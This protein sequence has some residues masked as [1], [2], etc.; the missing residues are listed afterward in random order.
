MKKYLIIIII[1]N[2][3]LINAQVGSTCLTPDTIHSIPF[4]S[5]GHTT[6]G[7]GNNY[8]SSDLCN[9]VYTS[10]NDYVFMFKSPVDINLHITVNVASNQYG[11]GVFVVKNCPGSIYSECI[12]KDTA[13]SGNLEI[14]NAP[15]LAD[16]TYY[17]VLS[18]YDLMGMN[19]SMVFDIEITEAFQYDIGV[20]RYWSPRTSCGLTNNETINY[21]I[22][23][24]GYD[25]LYNFNLAYTVNGNSPNTENI[26]LVLE[27]GGRYNYS[28]SNNIDLS[29]VGSNYNL[30]IYTEF[31]LDENLSNDTFKT[32]ITN[33]NYIN[34]FPYFEDFESGDGGW[35][36]GQ[37]FTANSL[38]TATSWELGIPS[39]TIIN[40]ASSGINAW[41][42]SLDSNS[43]VNDKSYI[44]GPCFDLSNMQLPVL[45]LDIWYETNTYDYIEVQYSTDYG[46]SFHVLGTIN[47]GN[48][49]YNSQSN[50]TFEGWN[51]SSGGW[52]HAKH[53]L[54]SVAGLSDV[55]IR[56]TFNGGTVPAEGVA[57]D[58]IEIHESPFKDI[59]VISVISPADDCGY[60]NAEDI[61][62]EIFNYGLDTIFTFPISY[63]FNGGTYI[64]EIVNDTI[65]FNDSYFYTFANQIDISAI[66]DYQL[67]VKTELLLDESTNNDSI[68]YNF[69]NFENIA[70]F[71][72]IEDFESTSG[73]WFVKGDNVSWQWG[74]PIDTVITNAASGNNVWA[75][76]LSGYY[77]ELEESFLVGPC[78]DLAN[79]NNPFVKLNVWHETQSPSGAQLESSIDNGASWQVVGVSATVDTNWYTSGYMWLGE[80]GDW[81]N[82]R[83]SISNLIGNSDV[84]FRIKFIGVL[85]Y[86]GVA[87]DDFE[88]CDAPLASFTSTNAGNQFEFTNTSINGNSFYWVFSDG[89]TFSTSD[90]SYHINTDSISCK[91]YVSNDCGIDSTNIYTIYNTSVKSYETN[92]GLYPNP[93]DETLNLKINDLNYTVYI[94][95]IEGIELAKYRKLQSNKINVQFLESGYYIIK[96]V[97]EN[98][99]RTGSFVKN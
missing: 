7:F 58:N 98:K 64:T 11:P 19:P 69:T 49:W 46:N 76:N 84:Q 44:M 27:P 20:Y 48:N 78:F 22:I 43:N 65:I 28:F 79:M 99:T 85:E 77:N 36:A 30:E 54:D 70:I 92:I 50:S 96:V 41:V 93:V 57:I 91:L 47:E 42:T 52:L 62:V 63:S 81:K 61:T 97:S 26:N 3:L 14:L 56:I 34:V 2:S 67:I 71:P 75:T 89:T 73:N 45:E 17:I 66:S 1:S 95:N 60:T 40:S 5:T 25:T 74:T 6:V 82:V 90:I 68:I 39:N 4:I 12:A 33:L 38:F 24:L 55:Q 10:G 83:H 31:L 32:Q 88:I 51:G 9:S 59:G 80:Y 8:S 53:T 16:S 23:N 13:D 72:Y 87:I 29:I 86:T 18:T 35:I 15:I 21:E 37:K 94:Y